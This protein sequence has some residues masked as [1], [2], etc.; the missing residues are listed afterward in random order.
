MEVEC[1]FQSP[2]CGTLA[3][4]LYFKGDREDTWRHHAQKLW[5]K[6][7]KLYPVVCSVQI[8]TGRALPEPWNFWVLCKVMP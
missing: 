7:L 4:Y 5:I 2:C 8:S 6:L 3:S 1:S